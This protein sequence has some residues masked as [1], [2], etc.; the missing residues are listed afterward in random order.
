MEYLKTRDGQLY[1][2]TDE[3]GVDD[4]YLHGKWQPV[5]AITFPSEDEYLTMRVISA[6]EA[7][8]LQT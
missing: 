5:D 2:R 7:A 8:K 1:R 3:Y 6:A 4:I